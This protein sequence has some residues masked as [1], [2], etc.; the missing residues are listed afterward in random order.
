MPEE[1]VVNEVTIVNGPEQGA[2]AGKV[3]NTALSPDGLGVVRMHERLD[4]HFRRWLNRGCKNS[5]L[6]RSAATLSEAEAL[7]RSSS[8]SLDGAL[9][10]YLEK[11]LQARNRRRWVW[12]CTTLAAGA[13]AVALLATFTGNGRW[14]AGTQHRGAAELALAGTRGIDTAA[15]ERTA[16]QSHSVTGDGAAQGSGKGAESL[17]NDRDVSGLPSG[18]TTPARVN[19]AGQSAELAASRRDALQAK[20]KEA[21]E[22]MKRTAELAARERDAFRTQ[23]LTAAAKARHDAE[24]AANEQNGL[25]SQ[26][27]EAEIRAQRA[28]KSAQLATEQ[29]DALQS[30]LR[31]AESRADAA[32]KRAELVASQSDALQTRLTDLETK[33]HLAQENLE[34]VTSQRDSLQARLEEAQAAAA[35][36]E[37]PNGRPPSRTALLPQN[38]LSNGLTTV[39]SDP[40]RIQP[41]SSGVIPFSDQTNP[42]THLK[43]RE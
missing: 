23:L 40:E 28:E 4:A 31:E 12:R 37:K 1:I 5:D 13:V 39:P 6:L 29:R 11:S 8:Q 7:R 32:R 22:T 14:T 41:P 24:A 34:R 35:V 33:A 19:A 38:G 16:G 20:L 43:R 9:A 15:A 17:A 3:E 42:D 30:Q 10:D 25:R 18:A 27:K 36:Q 21:E 2:L 26:L